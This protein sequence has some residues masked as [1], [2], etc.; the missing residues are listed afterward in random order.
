MLFHHYDVTVDTVAVRDTG[1][2]FALFLTEKRKAI[3][4]YGNY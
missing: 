3:T 4:G 2:A 1:I